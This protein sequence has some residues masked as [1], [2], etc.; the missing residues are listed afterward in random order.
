MIA[1][2][3]PPFFHLAYES[4]SVKSGK[5]LH[6]YSVEND[7]IY[8]LIRG[9]HLSC[10]GV[11]IKRDITMQFRFNEDRNL[12]G[13][14]DW[15]LW[16]RLAAHFGLKTDKRISAAL[17]AH[18]ARSVVD[19]DERKLPERKILALDY[20]FEDTE[21][22]RIFGKHRKAMEAYSFTYISL[23]FALSGINAKAIHYLKKALVTW[24]ASLFNIRTL[25]ILKYLILNLFNAK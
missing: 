22:R 9:N 7:D 21:V 13:S 11:F 5:S 15:E 8:S 24:P 3:F 12:S 4:R 23:H 6:T 18:E 17:M 1:N 2:K 19:Y 14:E 20:A 25:A 10:L 16:L